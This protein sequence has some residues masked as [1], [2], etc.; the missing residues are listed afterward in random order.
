M[1]RRIVRALPPS[2]YSRVRSLAMHF[3]RLRRQTVSMDFAPVRAARRR[4]IAMSYYAPRL[5]QIRDWA[6]KEKE[7]SNFY[8]ALTD[9]N[10]EHLAHI[11]STVTGR[12]YSD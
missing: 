1:L 7:T 2:L 9:L 8:Y 4:S 10:R 3:D 12:A 11:V 6:G 5:K